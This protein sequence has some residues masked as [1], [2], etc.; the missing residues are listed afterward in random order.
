[1]L[2]WVTRPKTTGHF[3]SRSK[4][5]GPKIPFPTSVS[6][7][8]PPCPPCDVFLFPLARGANALDILACLWLIHRSARARIAVGPWVAAAWPAI[9][10]ARGNPAKKY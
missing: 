2:G 1:V 5:A 4:K 9:A 3:N 8:F 6:S 10:R 7:V